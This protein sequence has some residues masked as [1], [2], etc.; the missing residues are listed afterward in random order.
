MWQIIYSA[1]FYVEVFDS[2]H[3]FSRFYYSPVSTKEFQGLSFSLFSNFFTY[4]L[5]T[6]RQP[7]WNF[8]HSHNIRHWGLLFYN[9]GYDELP[10]LCLSLQCSRL[11]TR[12]KKNKKKTNMNPPAGGSFDQM[13]NNWAGLYKKGRDILGIGSG[14]K[15]FL[16]LF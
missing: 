5:L 2:L 3:P 1:A 15:Q 10:Y 4:I 14:Y 11:I 12:E 8:P 13:L 6:Y 16:L 7:K 9:L